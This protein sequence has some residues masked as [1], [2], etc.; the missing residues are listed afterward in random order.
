M[1]AVT[2]LAVSGNTV[3]AGGVF[4]QAGGNLASH[5]AK[6]DGSAWSALGSGLSER[7]LAAIC[8]A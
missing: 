5:V 8:N 1:L 3:Y 2:A 4:T 7:K 6:W